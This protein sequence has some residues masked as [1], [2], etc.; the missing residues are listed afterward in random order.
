MIQKYVNDLETIVEDDWKYDKNHVPMWYFKN[1]IPEKEFNLYFKFGFVRNP[2]DRLVSAYHYSV[3][4]YKENDAK[5]LNSKKFDNFSTW[6]RQIHKGSIL[7][8][9]NGSQLSFVEGCD[10]IGK[11]ENLQEDFNIVCDKIGIPQQQLP[12]KN[13]SKHTHYTE[14]YDDESCKIVA[15]QYAKDIEYFGYKFGE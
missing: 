5:E 7:P 13:K 9:K 3:K 12:H 1:I 11:F 10:F 14:Y 15:E 6:L 8:N 4:W 2:W